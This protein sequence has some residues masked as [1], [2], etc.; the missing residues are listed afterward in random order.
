M[1]EQAQTKTLNTLNQNRVSFSN[2]IVYLICNISKIW[3]EIF[4]SFSN[5]STPQKSINPRRTSTRTNRTNPF[6]QIF[7]FYT[8]MLISYYS[9]TLINAKRS[10]EHTS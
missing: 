1:V 8:N 7:L 5:L 3:L 4:T 9:A 6:T 2:S 10:E